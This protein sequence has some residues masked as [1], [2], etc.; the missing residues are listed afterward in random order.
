MSV[1]SDIEF[2][3]DLLSTLDAVDKRVPA[4]MK[5]S[6]RD[7]FKTKT[8]WQNVLGRLNYPVV[9]KPPAPKAKVKVTGSTRP[10]GPR[11]SGGPTTRITSLAGPA[12]SRSSDSTNAAL[13]NGARTKLMELLQ[14]DVVASTGGAASS[15]SSA[16]LISA[17]SPL[18][19]G[20]RPLDEFAYQLAL[21]IEQS[22][23][24][25]HVVDGP[26][27]AGGFASDVLA[28][29]EYKNHYRSI[30]HNLKNNLELKH[31]LVTKNLSATELTELPEAELA[32]AEVQA[33]RKKMEEETMKD[34]VSK[35]SVIP[36]NKWEL[37]ENWG[38]KSSP[39]KRGAGGG[40]GGASSS[41]R[42][43][44]SFDAGSSF[45]SQFSGAG[46]SPMK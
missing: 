42:G 19:N 3:A 12:S 37:P 28:V 5:I 6:I 7:T 1:G 8:E 13:R 11:N 21:D 4:H 16:V 18:L 26:A 25:K 27:R 24:N 46:K 17:P 15:S 39:D 20:A 32:T 35:F 44:G 10:P 33:S 40:T 23:W 36:K 14:Q 2:G 43:L 9:K 38:K 22:L 31:K 29:T 30:S 45:D 34:H 41:L